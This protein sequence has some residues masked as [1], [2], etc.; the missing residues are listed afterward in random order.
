MKFEEHPY[1]SMMEMMVDFFVNKSNSP[2][3]P[4][5]AIPSTP[6]N[7]NQYNNLSLT[8]ERSGGE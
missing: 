6:S 3:D 8:I 5:P 1:Q 7:G 4:P 2:S